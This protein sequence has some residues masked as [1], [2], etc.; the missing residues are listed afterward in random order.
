MNS[1]AALPGDSWGTDVRHYL[2]TPHNIGGTLTCETLPDSPWD[3]QRYYGKIC[4]CP[5]VRGFPRDSQKCCQA[6]S[7]WEHMWCTP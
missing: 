5:D 2:E 6:G 4:L 3:S 1:V 7:H